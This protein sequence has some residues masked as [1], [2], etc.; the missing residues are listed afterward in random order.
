MCGRTRMNPAQS[1]PRLNVRMALEDG[2]RA[3]T[4]APWSFLGFTLLLTALQLLLAA[5]QPSFSTDN[6]PDS[7]N[8]A[9][10]ADRWEALLPWLRY[11]TVSFCL[12]VLNVLAGIVLNLWGG[13]GLVRGA[14]IALKGGRPTL[15]SFTHWDGKALLRLYLPGFLLGCGIVA[16]VTMLLLLAV[17]LSYANVFLALLPALLVLVGACY[18]SVSQAFLPQVALLHDDHPFAALAQGRQVVDRCWP[19][20]VQLMLLTVGL[21]LLGLLAAG[22]GLFVAWPLAVCVVTAAYQQ[23]FGT[24]DHTGFT[25]D[26]P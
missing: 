24:T 16:T 17:V 13:S 1:S 7:I 21:L 26:L 12:L 18:I 8:P 15:A 22:V 19:Q 11:G 20:V 9:L 4:R 3:F 14:W 23:L 10:T 2:W 5:L 25:H 6:L